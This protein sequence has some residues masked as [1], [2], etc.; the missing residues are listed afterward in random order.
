M[1]LPLAQCENQLIVLVKIVV[2]HQHHHNSEIVSQTSL[3]TESSSTVSEQHQQCLDINQE[4][5]LLLPLTCH[6]TLNSKHILIGQWFRLYIAH[7]QYY[8][9]R[10]DSNK[11]GSITPGELQAAL[12]NGNNT[13]FNSVTINMMISK[14]RLLLNCLKMILFEGLFDHDKTGEITFDEF[15]SLWRYVIDWQNCFKTFDK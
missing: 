7:W 6:H 12:V 1:P 11:S 2:T 14:I 9:F 8:Y 10:V 3:S 15:G 5:L 4:D 13:E